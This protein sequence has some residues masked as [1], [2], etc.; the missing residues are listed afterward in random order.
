MT[1][2]DLIYR[3][4]KEIVK[5]KMTLIT[6]YPMDSYWNQFPARI[7]VLSTI[8]TEPMIINGKLYKTYPKIR[9]S[10]I[11]KNSSNKW[12][13]VATPNNARLGTFGADF[14]GDTISSKTPF[15]IEANQEL[16][17]LTNS[18]MNYIGLTGI[19]EITTSKEG[20]QALYNLTLVLPED[21]DK[22]TKLTLA[23][24]GY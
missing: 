23:D 8:E 9:K 2:A 5:D 10:D 22:M 16:Y 21:K 14:D 6:R 4:A 15:S 1:W 7:V 11:L 19:N 13:D 20:L 12:I 18:K 17:D 3:A 24:F